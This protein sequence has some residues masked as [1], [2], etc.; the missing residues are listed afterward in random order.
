[1]NANI[2]VILGPPSSQ[3]RILGKNVSN[4]L[5][6]PFIHFS[7]F[8]R[9]AII[10]NSLLGQQI[11]QSLERGELLSESLLNKLIVSRFPVEKFKG[12]IVNGYPR[13]VEQIKSLR[14]AYPTVKC[15]GIHLA[16]TVT[17]PAEMSEEIRSKIAYHQ[18]EQ[19]LLTDYFIQEGT[20]IELRENYEV[21]EIAEKLT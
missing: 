9:E 15:V 1:M 17:F 18:A 20:L 4:V 14:Q 5:G 7:D 3:S 6:I 21:N 16:Y 8:I 11:S 13:T 19:K 2:Y 12:F 10:S